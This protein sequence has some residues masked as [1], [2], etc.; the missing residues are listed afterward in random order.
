MFAAATHLNGNFPFFF[1]MTTFTPTQNFPDSL[2]SIGKITCNVLFFVRFLTAAKG[3]YTNIE[4]NQM[5]HVMKGGRNIVVF[6]SVSLSSLSEFM[7]WKET[8]PEIRALW[9]SS[10]EGKKA[11]MTRNLMTSIGDPEENS[12]TWV[13]D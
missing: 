5:S 7:P 8:Q 13:E 4:I 2:T 12:L 3:R 11:L 10:G 1:L 9:K 6:L